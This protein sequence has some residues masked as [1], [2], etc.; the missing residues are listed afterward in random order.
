MCFSC[1]SMS[2]A[3]LLR[4]RERMMGIGQAITIPLFFARGAIVPP[5]SLMPA[6]LRMYRSPEPADLCRGCFAGTTTPELSSKLAA[7]RIRSRRRD[8]SIHGARV[9]FYQ[10][11]DRLNLSLEC[12]GIFFLFSV[13]RFS[14]NYCLRRGEPRD[15]LLCMANMRY[16]LLLLH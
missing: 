2:I 5:L 7:G 8:S 14:L 1:L 4:T 6:W 3:S 10:T 11:A 12:R 9:D 16:S 15:W 13:D